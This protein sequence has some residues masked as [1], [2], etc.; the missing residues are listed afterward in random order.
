MHNLRDCGHLQLLLVGVA[1]VD[2]AVYTQLEFGSS[3]WN[4]KLLG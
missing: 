3:I 1:M 4:L 2:D